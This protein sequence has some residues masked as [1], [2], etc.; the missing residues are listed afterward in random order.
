MVT[1]QAAKIK[2]LENNLTILNTKMDKVLEHFS[3]GVPNASTPK[4]CE[5]ISNVW[6]DK[7]KLEKVKAP[8]PKPVLVLKKSN[9]EE[10]SKENLEIV[11]SAIMTNGISIVE[12]YKNKTGDLMVVCE[13]SETREELKNIVLSSNE[14]IVLNMPKEMKPGITIVGLPKEYKK[15]EILNMLVMQNSFIKNFSMSNNLDEHITIYSV[16]PLKKDPST[17]QVFA[18]V[19]SI[20]RE[21]IRCYRDKV[22]LGLTSCKVYDR[23]HVKRCNNCQKFGHYAKDCPTKDTHVCGNCSEDHSTND[24]KSY[25]RKCINCVRE[26]IDDVKHTTN[27][28]DCPCYIKQ[29]ESLKKKQNEASLNLKWT[30]TIPYR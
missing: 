14:E 19:S 5:D 16:K 25:E 2:T 26:N 28:F 24:C 17:Y 7:E 29:Q 11:E 9:D 27:S 15:E 20:L 18:N 3:N 1:S 6:L 12:S 22:I 23:Y 30:N 4:V 21:G 13:S 8:A 10:K